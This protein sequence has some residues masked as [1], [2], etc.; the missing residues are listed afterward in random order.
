MRERGLGVEG[1]RFGS[2]GKVVRK[3]RDRGLRVAGKR[4]GSRGK[5]V[6]EVRERGFGCYR[7]E[8]WG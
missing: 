5:E 8:V 1:K 4:I 7:K 2:R 3:F 6:W